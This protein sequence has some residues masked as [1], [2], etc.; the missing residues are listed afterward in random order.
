MHVHGLREDVKLLYCM[1]SDVDRCD[2][3]GTPYRGYGTARGPQSPTFCGRHLFGLL[4]VVAHPS[5]TTLV[6]R[7]FPLP[8]RFLCTTRSL[9]EST[10]WL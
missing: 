9:L 8:L 5:C 2:A 3:R 10:F 1:Y 4:V 6:V 7:V